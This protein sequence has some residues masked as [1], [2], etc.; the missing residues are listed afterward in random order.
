MIETE[1]LV[2]RPWREDDILPFAEINRDK[3]VMEYLP[4]C[5]SLEET[6]QFYNRI[7]AEHDSYGYGLYAVE[8][9]SDGS[10]IGYVGFHHFD[11]DA[12]FS[13]GVEIGWRLARKFWC[14]GY[15]TEAAKA[16]LDYAKQHRLFNE[17]YSFTTVCNH[18][19]ERVMQKIGMEQLGFFSHPALPI[20]HKLKPHVL[21]KLN[22][23]HN[24]EMEIY[25]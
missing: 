1:R 18:R 17:I 20:G 6:E 13:P 21:Y 12:E 5:L 3:D 23:C 24:I 19:S 2:L 16:C 15:A 22:L 8:A 7:I 10:F 9:K 4:K 11:F 14:Q 25:S